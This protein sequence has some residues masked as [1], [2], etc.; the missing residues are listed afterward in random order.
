[1]ARLKPLSGAV[2]GWRRQGIRHALVVL[3][4]PPAAGQDVPGLETL[5]ATLQRR[6]DAPETLQHTPVVGVFAEGLLLS[7]I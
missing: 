2:S 4:A 1:M 3:A 5:L 6:G 7:W